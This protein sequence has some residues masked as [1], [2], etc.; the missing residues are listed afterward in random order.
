M[1]EPL[2]P[3]WDQAREILSSSEAWVFCGYSLPDYDKAVHNLLLE[4]AS[5]A[6]SKVYVRDLNPTPVREKLSALLAKAKP[7]IRI[8]EGPGISCTSSD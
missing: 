5:G 4:S 3:I 7:S 8:E 6:T 1:F 2:R